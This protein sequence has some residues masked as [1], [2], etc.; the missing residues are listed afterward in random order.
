MV[1]TFTQSQEDEKGPLVALAILPMVA[2]CM[3]HTRWRYLRVSLKP[4]C[5]PHQVVIYHCS[6]TFGL[7]P[8]WG[9]EASVVGCDIL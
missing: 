1:L 8:Q 9:Q 7:E 4:P 5:D 3:S 6:L 2:D